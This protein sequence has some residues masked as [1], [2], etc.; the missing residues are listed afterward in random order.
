MA[1]SGWQA[2]ATKN[3]LRF[4]SEISLLREAY[5][6]GNFNRYQVRQETFSRSTQFSAASWGFG[7]S[8]KSIYTRMTLRASKPA[9]LI[10]PDKL[11]AT[12]KIIDLLI[13]K[14]VQQGIKGRFY[15]YEK[16][17][18]IVYEQKNI[19]NIP[20]TASVHWLI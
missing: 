10:S 11:S 2:F 6:V 8:S 18:E 20:H 15:T 13:P 12:S 4:K 17:Q 3:N 19:E 9:T 7:Y 16:G 14:D 5:V 1:N